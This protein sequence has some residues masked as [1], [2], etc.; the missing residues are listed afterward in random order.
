MDFKGKREVLINWKKI[1]PK[2]RELAIFA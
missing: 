2:K 1:N